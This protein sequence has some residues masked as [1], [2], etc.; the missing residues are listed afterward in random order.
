MPALVELAAREILDS[1]GVPTIEVDIRL[2]SGARGRAA[3]PSGGS[4]GKREATELRDNDQNRYGGA[5]VR[6]AVTI[7]HEV[8]A[9]ALVGTNF[10]TIAALDRLLLELD[11]TPQRS[12]LGANAMLAVSMAVT[13][14]LAA[15]GRLHEHLAPADQ[16]RLPVPMFNVLN[17]GAHANNNVDFQEFMIAPIGA[18][19]FAEALRMGVETYWALR[20]VLKR[21][22]KAT[23]VGDEGGFAPDLD[24]HAEAFD[25]LMLAIEQAGLRPAKDIVIAV[26]A[27]AGEL[28]DG[29]TYVFRKS[30]R[31]RRTTERMIEFYANCL[32][33]F[34]IW[35]IEDGLAETDT[36]GWR[37]LTAALGTRVQL[38]GDDLFVTNASL[39]R[40]GITDGI[41]N[42]VL[43]KPN[44]IGTVSETLET[45]SE[46]TRGG[47]GVIISHRAGETTDDFIADLAVASGAGQIKAGAPVRGERVAKYNQLLRLEE[48]LGAKA[49][50]AGRQF[51]ERGGFLCS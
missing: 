29:D 44:Q 26:D 3:A 37:A 20:A 5:G 48:T 47:Y 24:R 43:I 25:L 8:I 46:A 19:N 18:P 32:R 34:P 49:I 39:L 15:G 12:Q 28:A 17:G 41:A 6:R 16:W 51:R 9:P 31:R 11:G 27:A 21:R 2:D 1:R 40:E 4:K 10:E 38:V 22:G 33:Q 30:M 7:V 23:S 50:Y 13:R 35:S 42:A 45:I 36:D 14:A